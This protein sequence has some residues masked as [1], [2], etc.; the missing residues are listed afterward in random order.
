MTCSVF[1]ARA[2]SRTRKSVCC[3]LFAFAFMYVSNN[4]RK[5]TRLCIHT[6]IQILYRYHILIF[7]FSV[8]S[9]LLETVDCLSRLRF[10]F[11]N[12]F[13]VYFSTC[14]CFLLIYISV[15]TSVTH[16][17]THINTF[18]GYRF[19]NLP[20]IVFVCSPWRL[21]GYK[22]G[23]QQTS[24]QDMNTLLSLIQVSL[25]LDDYFEQLRKYKIIMNTISIR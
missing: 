8:D 5:L 17:C 24:L 23:C 21:I 11:P 18:L 19:E 4:I 2:R 22:C 15:G 12:Q 14:I 9:L 6:R 25:F 10:Y 3:F 16:L 13:S 1:P 7:S 20:Y